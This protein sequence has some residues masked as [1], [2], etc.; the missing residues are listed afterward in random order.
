MQLLVHRM[1]P[2]QCERYVCMH[3]SVTFRAC[4]WVFDMPAYVYP[5]VY[6][7]HL[8]DVVRLYWARWV[9]FASWFCAEL[10]FL[11]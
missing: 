8:Q 6:V 1:I 10:C 9:G 2:L 7:V 5:Y 3:V 4:A 11:L